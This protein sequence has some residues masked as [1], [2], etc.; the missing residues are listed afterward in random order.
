MWAWMVK[1]SLLPRL[2]RQLQ[3]ALALTLLASLVV[4]LV[5]I[6]ENCL[7]AL[8]GITCWLN[9]LSLSSP[10]VIVNKVRGGDMATDFEG[11]PCLTRP[12]ACVMPGGRQLVILPICWFTVVTLHAQTL[13]HLKREHEANIHLDIRISTA[14]H[15]LR[16][17]LLLFTAIFVI[18]WL[19]NSIWQVPGVTCLKRRGGAEKTPCPV[20]QVLSCKPRP[21]DARAGRHGQALLQYW[22]PG[23]HGLLP[24]EP[25]GPRAAGAGVG[26]A[27]LQQPPPALVG[28]AAR[29]R[30]RARRPPQALRHHL[31]CRYAHRQGLGRPR[32]RCWVPDLSRRC[33]V[34]WGWAGKCL[35]LKAMGRVEDWI[36]AR[37]Y[38]LHVVA[39]QECKMLNQLRNA[40]HRHLGGPRAFVLFHTEL[41]DD[42]VSHTFALGPAVPVRQASCFPLSG[43][44]SVAA[45]GLCSRA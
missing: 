37:G 43:R 40:I 31:E 8:S 6:A 45:V 27:A 41:G 36:P 14:Y 22:V 3:W 42:L 34:V 44:T 24:G 15:R 9:T 20:V 13:L 7:G 16:W 30:R 39:V 25:Y 4:S 29:E 32:G 35:G 28:P 38:D 12:C 18:T 17:R 19:V 5:P 21:G 11:P 2:L 1:K 23:R 26:G 33:G 10:S